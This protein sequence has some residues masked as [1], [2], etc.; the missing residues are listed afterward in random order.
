MQTRLLEQSPLCGYEPERL[1]RLK[2]LRH[3][4]GLGRSTIYRL[5]E[6]GR[7]PKQLRPLGENVKLAVWRATEVR[8]WIAARANGEPA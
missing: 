3:L 8:Q 4:T 7:F 5:I 6:Q 1:I 2:E